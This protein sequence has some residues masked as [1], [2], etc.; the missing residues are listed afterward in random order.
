[1]ISHNL[2]LPR[3]RFWGFPSF[4]FAQVKKQPRPWAENPF[5]VNFHEETSRFAGKF[6]YLISCIFLFS[7]L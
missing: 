5:F 3:G 2:P 4:P 6:G 1:M 7:M